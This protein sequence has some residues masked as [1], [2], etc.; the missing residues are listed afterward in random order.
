MR[1]RSPRCRP[2]QLAAA[3]VEGLPRESPVISELDRLALPPAAGPE[4]VLP[5]RPGD[6]RRRPRHPGRRWRRPRALREPLLSGAVF[7]HHPRF[8]REGGPFWFQEFSADVRRDVSW[9]RMRPTLEGGDVLVLREDLLAIGYSERTEKTTIERLAEAL[10]RGKSPVR[11]IV[12]VGI[13]PARSYMHLDT[14]FTMV[15]AG[16]GLCYAPMI[17]PGGA[18]EADVYEADLT[19]REV[20]WTTADDL[21]SALRRPE[22]RPRADPVRRRPTRS[23]SSAS[24]GRTA[25]TRSPSRPGVILC[26]ERNERTAEQLAGRGY[27]IVR[28]DD[29]L[30][31]RTELD[32]T[33]AAEVRDPALLDRARPRARR[34]PLHDDAARARVGLRR[35][36]AMRRGLLGRPR[37][38]SVAAALSAPAARAC[39]TAR[40]PAPPR[41][42]AA[43]DMAVG[44]ASAREAGR[45]GLE[46]PAPARRRDRAL[47]GPPRIPITERRSPGRSRKGRRGGRPR[48]ARL[49]RDPDGDGT[50]LAFVPARSIRLHPGRSRD[51]FG[52]VAPAPRDRPADRP[53]HPGAGRRRDAGLA[54]AAR[55]RRPPPRDNRRSI[56]CSSS[57]TKSMGRSIGPRSRGPRSRSAVRQTTGSS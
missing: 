26:Y 6:R 33:R 3:L 12:V 15:S 37:H 28:D 40:P 45:G 24:S 32:R 53:A 44:P 47:P 21:L 36:D 43:L 11:R 46:N 55:R 17:L 50:A 16:R 1:T 29:L 13:P 57:S 49:L 41:A 42:S 18:E 20:V 8:A 5:A 27:A 9:A 22:A 51:P 52:H 48:R 10:R 38:L 4:L 19:G 34:T 30:L 7:A 2:T 31:G 25:R 54:A 56:P 23:T 35:G 14:V 39:G